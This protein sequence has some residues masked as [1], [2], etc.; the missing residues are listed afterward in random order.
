MNGWYN[1][2][3]NLARLLND[4]LRQLGVEIKACALLPTRNLLGLRSVRPETVLDVGAN[5]GQFVLE[6]KPVFPR[7]KF[8]SFEPLP[9]CFAQLKQLSLRDSKWEC[10][11]L[12]LGDEIKAAE[13]Y[14]H[15]NHTSSSSFL[16][17]AEKHYELYP[18]TVSQHAVMVQCSTL[19]NWIRAHPEAGQKPI[20]LKID[21]QG[22]E[23]NVLRGAK[24][25]LPDVEAVI[26]EVIVENLYE[27]QPLFSEQVELLAQAGLHFS[28][29]I[30]HAFDSEG[31]VISFDGVFRRGHRA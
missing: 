10:F 21:V 15:A 16:Q 19:D 1:I 25:T 2:K 14:V 12:A 30:Q 7:A 6:F 5:T 9:S 29:V 4:Q 31:K 24:S 13:F 26:T 8:F 27:K 3:A 17:A 18:E 11:N 22:Y 28:G 20:V 23:A